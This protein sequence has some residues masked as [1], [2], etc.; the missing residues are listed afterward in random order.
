MSS[1]DQTVNQI[2]DNIL[3][4]IIIK[5]DDNNLVHCD[6]G[7]AIYYPNGSLAYYNHGKKHNLNGPAI[8]CGKSEEYFVNGI[9]CSNI[10]EYKHEV[11]KFKLSSFIE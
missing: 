1:S 9:K 11:L 2:T 8:I 4:K 5:Y 3:S 10:D 7:P 6:D